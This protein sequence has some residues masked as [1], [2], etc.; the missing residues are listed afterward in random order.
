M[1]F[2]ISW[3]PQSLRELGAKKEAEW[4]ATNQFIWLTRTLAHT[5]DTGVAE[6]TPKN[7]YQQ[8]GEKSKENKEKPARKSDDSWAVD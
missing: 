4:E 5:Q 8:G 3:E 1:L 2:S 7:K 6:P